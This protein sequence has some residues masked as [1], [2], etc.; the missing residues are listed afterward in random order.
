MPAAIVIGAGPGLGRSVARRFATHGFSVAALARRPETVEPLAREL[1]AMGAAS[2]ALAADVTD[3]DSLRSALDRATERFGVPDVVVYNAA[4]IQADAPTALPARGH[5][6]AWAVNVVGALTT[7][8]HVLPAMAERGSG[9]F[10][11]T[12]GMPEPI[13]AYTSLS[14]GKAGV[15]A[16]VQ[17]LD[18]EYRSAGLHVATVTV[19]GGIAP[20]TR[21]DPDG[22]AEHYWRLHCQP[23][24]AWQ[25]EL[26][27]T[28]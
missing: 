11:V 12:G 13:A 10:L 9:S 25:R 5:L 15:R 19:F 20:G 3:E 17:V 6:D 8:G 14:L 7:A 24:G 2:L 22:I 18:E 23:L 28:G 16:L 1:R 26:A 4:R 21:F 27:Y